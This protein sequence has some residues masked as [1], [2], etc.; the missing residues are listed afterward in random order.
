[1][2]REA[3]ELVEKAAEVI[4]EVAYVG[5]DVAIGRN[6]P[7]LIEGNPFPGVFQK[8]AS[9]TENKTGIIPLYRQYM[10]I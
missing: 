10:E 7:E 2:F 8:R 5:W 1:M 4:P 3:I 9:L 6:G